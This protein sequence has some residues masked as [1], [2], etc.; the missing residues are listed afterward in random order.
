M[1][2]GLKA[3]AADKQT[4]EQ[5]RF[6]K[7]AAWSVEGRLAAEG[8]VGEVQIESLGGDGPCAFGQSGQRFLAVTDLE[9][10]RLRRRKYIAIEVQLVLQK[11][12]HTRNSSVAEAA[13]AAVE[14]AV[15][16]S[17]VDIGAEVVA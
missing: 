5:V 12:F 3:E 4:A 6:D 1:P 10:R 16:R 7:T 11:C 15:G 17:A 8:V 14:V 13:L 2:S 9:H